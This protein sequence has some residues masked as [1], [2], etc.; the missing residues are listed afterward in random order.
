MGYDSFNSMITMGSVTVFVMFYLIKAPW[1]PCYMKTIN[2]SK[3][4]RFRKVRKALKKLVRNVLFH[5][6]HTI[7]IEGYLEFLIALYFNV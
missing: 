5:D 4:K 1:I 7:L 6:I 2:S 3:F